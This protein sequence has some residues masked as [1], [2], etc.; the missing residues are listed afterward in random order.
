MW[1]LFVEEGGRAPARDAKSQDRMTKG[2]RTAA[3]YPCPGGRVCLFDGPF[4]PALLPPTHSRGGIDE[5]M[6]QRERAR[7]CRLGVIP[8]GGGRGGK[9]RIGLQGA[10]CWIWQRREGS[11]EISL[12]AAGALRRGAATAHWG[13]V[14][15][16][17][18][19]GRTNDQTGGQDR[20]GLA[21]HGLEEEAG[22]HKTGKCWLGARKKSAK[23]GHK[24]GVSEAERWHVGRAHAKEAGGWV[25][26]TEETGR[27][28]RTRVHEWQKS[29]GRRERGQV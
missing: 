12:V 23:M 22:R 2:D 6:D 16:W 27:H 4:L 20:S 11:K 10:Q 25:Y 29:Q 26:R 21:R 28:G 15:R 7:T 17:R 14:P 13:D 8:G 5:K 19:G 9:L 1:T 18:G 24:S 3:R